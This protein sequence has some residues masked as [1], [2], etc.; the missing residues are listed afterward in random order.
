MKISSATSSTTPRTDVH[1]TVF[2]HRTSLL[3]SVHTRTLISVSDYVITQLFSFE[4]LPQ[5]SETTTNWLSILLIRLILLVL[6]LPWAIQ[7][8]LRALWWIYQA[9]SCSC[10]YGTCRRNCPRQCWNCRFGW[11]GVLTQ[12]AAE[13]RFIWVACFQYHGELPSLLTVHSACYVLLGK[14]G[15]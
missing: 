4:F 15:S 5:Y 7:D 1:P 12:C 8:P 10:W 3:Y 11:I 2:P 14:C 6:C 9:R 13:V